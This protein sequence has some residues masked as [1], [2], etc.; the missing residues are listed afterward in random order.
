MKT[1][2]GDTCEVVLKFAFQSNF[3]PFITLVSEYIQRYY[4]SQQYPQ[5]RGT[6]Y[7]QANMII[8][9]G[10]SRPWDFSHPGGACKKSRRTTINS[11][12]DKHDFILFTGQSLMISITFIVNPMKTIQSRRMLCL[13]KLS[14]TIGQTSIDKLIGS[15]GSIFLPKIIM[16]ECTACGIGDQTSYLSRAH[17]LNYL[18]FF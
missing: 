10:Y 8:A 6:M 14:Q 9:C 1:V 2:T 15:I 11:V 12:I 4:Q 18:I 3:T 5:R 7:L 13:L 17:V 16:R